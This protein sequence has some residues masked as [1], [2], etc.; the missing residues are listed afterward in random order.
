MRKFYLLAMA[1]ALTSSALLQTGCSSAKKT[2]TTT[3]EAVVPQST[4]ADV[5][6]QGDSDSG[7]NGLQTVHFPFDSFVITEEAETK[8][9]FNAEFLKNKASATVQIE[10][11]CDER[12]GIQYNLALGEKRANAAKR[13]L[14]QL[15][16]A[17]DRVR[18]ISYGKERP[19]DPGHTEAA[20]AK[21]RRANFV[22]TSH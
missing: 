8:L 18:I 21:N 9:K 1:L 2:E 14:T 7:T 22:I 10:G 19:L 6:L 20:W 16:I 13:R 11:H 3:E 5:N 12:G 15:G 4:D 17:A